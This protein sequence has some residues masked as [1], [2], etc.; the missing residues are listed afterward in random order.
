MFTDFYHGN[1]RSSHIRDTTG[2]KHPCHHSDAPKEESTL[3]KQTKFDAEER[4]TLNQH[5]PIISL[6]PLQSEEVILS[7]IRLC[8]LMILFPA[9]SLIPL[10]TVKAQLGSGWPTCNFA[11]MMLNLTGRSLLPVLAV[12]VLTAVQGEIY[13]FCWRVAAPQ[14]HFSSH[15]YGSDER[16]VC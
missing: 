3:Q 15:I 7:D 5:L 6:D 13:D 10:H 16:H 1:S 2:G 12:A 8:S 9:L 14:S 4:L 11:E